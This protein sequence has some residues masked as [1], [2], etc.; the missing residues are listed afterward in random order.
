MK[1]IQTLVGGADDMALLFHLETQ[2]QGKPSKFRR[3]ISKID[4]NINIKKP[5]NVPKYRK[6]TQYTTESK[7]S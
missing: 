1:T 3:N 7:R 2:M 5:Q 6:P 4:L